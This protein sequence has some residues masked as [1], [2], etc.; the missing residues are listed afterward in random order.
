MLKLD[1]ATDPRWMTLEPGVEV[2]VAP[3]HHGI[4]LA[5]N[6]TDAVAA[7]EAEGDGSAWTFAIN[8][9]VAERVI[10]DWRGVGDLD[11]NPLPV[12][13]EAVAALLR[14]RAAFNGFAEG[15]LGPW[16]GLIAEKK[17]SAPSPDG[18]SATAQATATD[19]TESAKTAPAA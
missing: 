2:L 19:A 4:W 16:M 5:A 6:M 9:A 12:T 13:P 17:G 8:L 1:L 11:G 14:R 18:T 15:Y 3:M 7:A 10:L